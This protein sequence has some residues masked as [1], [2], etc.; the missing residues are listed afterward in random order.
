M[1]LRCL[2]FSR[3]DDGVGPSKM[4]SLM[5]HALPFFSPNEVKRMPASSEVDP[6]LW[7]IKGHSLATL[8]PA[9]LTGKRLI[10][11]ASWAPLQ[12]RRLAG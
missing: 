5:I 3:P 4:H 2:P 11:L 1:K 6:I 12:Y 8:L 10:A 9:F 7:T